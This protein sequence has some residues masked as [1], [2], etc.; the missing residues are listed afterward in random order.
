MGYEVV[1]DIR[2]ANHICISFVAAIGFSIAAIILFSVNQ[3]RKTQ[4]LPA[5]YDKSGKPAPWLP[6]LPAALGL[7]SLYYFVYKE[8]PTYKIASRILREAIEQGRCRV[9]EGVV[10]NFHAVKTGGRYITE[11]DSFDVGE[12]HFSFS[13]TDSSPGY[14]EIENRGPLGDGINVRIYEYLGEIA[15]LEIQKWSP[16]ATPVANSPALVHVLK[17][18]KARPVEEPQRS[19]ED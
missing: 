3:W 1:Y 19:S 7:L 10:R 8:Y 6:F 13:N 15:R 11:I 4:G 2:T 17:E 18:M 5:I 14:K 9:S 12:S 16:Q